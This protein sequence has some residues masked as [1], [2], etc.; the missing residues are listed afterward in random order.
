MA[1]YV[2][3]LKGMIMTNKEFVNKLISRLYSKNYISWQKEIT[4]FLQENNLQVINTKDQL[5]GYSV[6]NVIDYYSEWREY[7]QVS[8]GRNIPLELTREQSQY[9]LDLANRLNSIHEL[10]FCWDDIHQAI[11]Q[12]LEETYVT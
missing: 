4:E 2:L 1:L 10:A 5:L 7:Y 8:Y 6:E 11:E 9:L 12:W 3:S